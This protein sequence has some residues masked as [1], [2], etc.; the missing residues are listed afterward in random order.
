MTP[1][2]IYILIKPDITL[3]FHNLNVCQSTE[4]HPTSIDYTVNVVN[5]T[6]RLWTQIA[7][8]ALC[9]QVTRNYECQIKGFYM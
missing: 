1:F 7:F 4:E 6:K 2:S 3:F 9:D 5:T 8:A